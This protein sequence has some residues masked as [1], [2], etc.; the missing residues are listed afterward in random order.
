MDR[1]HHV[2]GEFGFEELATLFCNAKLRAQQSLSGGGAQHHNHFRINQ[3]N[4]GP[5][6]WPARGNLLCVRFLVNATLAAR[7]PLKMLDDIGDVD[8]RTIDARFNQRLI[9]QSA[10]WSDKWLARQI[11]FVAWLLTDQ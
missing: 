9:E 5:Q 2:R 11:F 6:P 4:L 7:L 10:G 3:S 8:S 1:G